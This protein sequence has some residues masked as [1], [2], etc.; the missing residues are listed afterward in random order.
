MWGWVA[1]LIGGAI[2]GVLLNI[3]GSLIG[4]ALTALGIGVVSYVGV[5]T[6]LTFFKNNFVTSAGSLPANI[7]GILSLMQVGS[8]VS[9][10]MSAMVMRMTLQGMTSDTVKKWVKK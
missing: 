5:N 7:V 8:C 10:V 4:R 9:M 6:T 2:G 3:A 1:Q